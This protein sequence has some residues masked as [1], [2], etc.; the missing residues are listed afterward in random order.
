MS[1]ANNYAYERVWEIYKKLRPKPEDLV[2]P[3]RFFV[4]KG[5]FWFQYEQ[6][7]KKKKRHFFLFNDILLLC[8]KE[9]PG[10]YYLRIYITLRA[11]GVSVESID[12]PDFPIRLAT[13]NQIFIFYLQSEE[14]Q[15]LWYN[16]FD[17]SINGTHPEESK[18]KKTPENEAKE[19]D[20]NTFRVEVTNVTKEIEQMITP[21]PSNL[22]KSLP[23]V[24]TYEESSDGASSDSPVK[25]KKSQKK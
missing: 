23:G 1:V 14:A 6:K 3:T 24:K 18:K 8:R 13:R 11:Q 19:Q 17:A 5:K 12:G 2:S 7:K 9:G 22:K 25:K 20:I 21:P 4:R 15:T 10:R 16:E